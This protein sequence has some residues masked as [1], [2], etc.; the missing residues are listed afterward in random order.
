MSAC[1]PLRWSIR[2]FVLLSIA[3]GTASAQ[4]APLPVKFSGPPTVAAITAGDLMTRLYIYADDSLM[5]RE[6]GTEYNNKATAY[7]EGQVRRLGLQPA[8]DDGGYFQNIGIIARAFDTT[9]STLTIEGAMYKAGTDFIANTSGS[10]HAVSPAAVVVWGSVF[11]TIGNP[12]ADQYNGKWIVI[13]NAAPPQGFDQKVFVASAGYQRFLAMQQSQGIVG[14]ITIATTPELNPNL[15]RNAVNATRSMMSVR[16]IRPVTITVTPRVGEALLGA[17]PATAAPGTV[18]KNL[19]VDARFTDSPRGGRNVLAMLPG[20]DPKLKGQYV[21]IGAHNDHVGFNNRPVDHDSLKVWLAVAR[22]QGA[23]GGAPRQLTAEDWA[24]V[25]ARIAELRIANPPRPDSI[26]NGADDDGSGSVSVLEIAEAFAKGKVKPKRSIIFLWQTGEESGMWGSSYFMDHPTVPR[27]SIVT[28]LN[29]DMVGRGA[30]SD[31]TGQSMEGGLLHGAD[32]YVQLVGSRRLSTELGNLVEEVNRQSKSNFTLDYGMDA[33]GH[34]Q[35]IYCRSDH[36][37]FGKWGVPVVFF[38]TGG[39]A[40][41][42]QVTD[43]PQYIR[44]DHLALLD[45]LI[46]DIA[47]RVANLDHR[48]LVDGVKPNPVPAVSCQQ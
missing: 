7:L 27:D 21:V 45:Q 31:V 25:N 47:V 22:P 24:Q 46:F 23:D 17:A 9:T 6:V 26:F 39:H 33:N 34:P 29:I 38:T 41:Y 14:R 36:W 43:E 3:A 48:P 12:T 2:L 44:Y 40:D 5:G 35:N 19:A 4:S 20:S 28:D 10:I 11:D 13:R 42:H 30:P 32:R 16:E 37:S 15:V 1:P 18:G 8:G